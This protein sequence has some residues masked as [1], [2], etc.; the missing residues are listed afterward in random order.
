MAN[1]F[2]I[3]G[4]EPRFD[5]DQAALEAAW[6]ARA[7]QTHP[8]LGGADA[9]DAALLN[10]AKL[11]L[12]DPERRANLLL[13]LRGGPSKEANRALPPEFLATVMEVQE[14]IQ[15]DRDAG[16]DL[17]RWRDWADEERRAVIK[18][19][20]DAFAD[21]PESPTPDQLVSIRVRLNQ[22]R[23]IERILEQLD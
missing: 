6:L 7:A 15:A 18:A 14:S 5:I 9:A 8:D 22:W 19:V 1:A 11:D 12:A 4:L 3:L 20:G 16:E 10:Q 23:Y 13:A 21:L 2:E 17:A